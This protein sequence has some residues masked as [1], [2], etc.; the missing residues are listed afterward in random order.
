MWIGCSEV[1]RKGNGV[2]HR[3]ERGAYDGPA[4]QARLNS[5]SATGFE[6]HAADLNRVCSLLEAERTTT[7]KR[8]HHEL[9][10]RY[11]RGVWDGAVIPKVQG[12]KD[13]PADT[14]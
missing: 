13:R 1:A 6:G 10:I 3:K 14:R 4:C 12:M 2:R 8:N 5:I 11:L 9:Q 7:Q